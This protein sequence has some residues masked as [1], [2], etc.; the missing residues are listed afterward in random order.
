M[1]R[2][3]REG[4]TETVRPVNRWSC[5]FVRCM[6][7]R[8]MCNEEK[9]AILRVAC[10]EHVRYVW[11]CFI[12][13]TTVSHSFIENSGTDKS[14]SSILI[15]CRNLFFVS[16]QRNRLAFLLNLSPEHTNELCG[17]RESIDIYSAFT[18][19]RNISN[20]N[21]HS[22]ERSLLSPGDFP[23]RRRRATSPGIGTLTHSQSLSPPVRI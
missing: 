23:L 1:T 16:S 17:A 19:P 3:F 5:D 7:N 10:E 12:S 6:N 14:F 9:R 11:N 2:L 20:W 22:F 21:L 8:N 15:F 18:S 4:R 13:T